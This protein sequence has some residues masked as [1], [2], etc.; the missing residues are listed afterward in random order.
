MGNCNGKNNNVERAT[1]IYSGTFDQ[2]KKKYKVDKKPI[3]K[4]SFG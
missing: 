3:G 1:S 4:G 2:I